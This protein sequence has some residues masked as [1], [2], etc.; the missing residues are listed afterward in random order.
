M[1]YFTG[2]LTGFLADQENAALAKLELE[3]DTLSLVSGMNKKSPRN[4]IVHVELTADTANNVE[5]IEWA[6]ELAG[7]TADFLNQYTYL[8]AKACELRIRVLDQ[9]GGPV[10]ELGSSSDSNETMFVEQPEKEY[11]AQT[12]AYGYSEKQPDLQLNKFGT[13][14]ETGELYVEYYVKD[15]YFDFSNYEKSVA[16]LEP[17]GEELG[18]YLLSGEEIREFMEAEDLETLTLSLYSGN[19]NDEYMTWELDV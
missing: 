3:P 17:I 19:L 18:E 2:E 12:W 9:N 1:E 14:P 7:R 8:R 15:S 10:T 4:L 5:S 13:L 6:D 11:A 16:G